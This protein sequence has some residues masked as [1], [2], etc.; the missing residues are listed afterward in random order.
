MELAKRILAENKLVVFSKTYC[1]Y[2]KRVKGLFGELGFH[3]FVFEL[4]TAPEGSDVQNYLNDLTKMS[5][6]PKVF[7]AGEFIGGCD[8]T[9][10]LHAKGGLVPKLHAVGL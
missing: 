3:P 8:S 9:T 6:V 5:T 10:S 1:G 2:C 4:D 7:I